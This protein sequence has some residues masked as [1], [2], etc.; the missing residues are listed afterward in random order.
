M[1]QKQQVTRR[2]RTT[3]TPT[4][5]EALSVVAQALRRGEVQ[6]ALEQDGQA[7]VNLQEEQ[8]TGRRRKVHTVRSKDRAKKNHN[9]SFNPSKRYRPG[10]TALREVRTYARSES[11]CL[12]KRSPMIRLIKEIMNTSKITVHG[13]DGTMDRVMPR[14]QSSAVDAIREAATHYMVDVFTDTNLC[15]LHAKRKTVYPK[16]IQ[17]ARRIRGEVLDIPLHLTL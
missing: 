1:S 3:K 11:K 5:H 2:K 12:L 17:L 7:N 8:I 4:R 6:A 10:A 15:A 16:D 13:A 9:V 14:I